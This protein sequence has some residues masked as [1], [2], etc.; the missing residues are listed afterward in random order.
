LRDGGGAGTIAGMI[1]S[2]KEWGVV[3]VVFE[4]G[5]IARLWCI[6]KTDAAADVPLL[7][8][9]DWSAIEKK[10]KSPER[11]PYC[12]FDANGLTEFAI[13]EVIRRLKDETEPELFRTLPAGSPG[14]WLT[15]SL[16]TV[17]NKTTRDNLDELTINGFDPDRWKSQQ[18]RKTGV[19]T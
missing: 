16:R 15:V 8:A 19:P 12:G 17:S 7:P 18:A 1:K 3:H 10:E 11:Q 9:I 5:R 2:P 4:D 14:A 13:D 6:P